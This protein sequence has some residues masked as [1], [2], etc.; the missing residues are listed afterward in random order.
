VI[1]RFNAKE[2]TPGGITLDYSKEVAKRLEAAG[3][4]LFN[5]TGGFYDILDY[6]QPHM[7][8]ED[9][10]EEEYYRFLNLAS[11]IKN[12]VDVP[13]V[14]GGLISDPF[15]AEK[16][17]EEGVVDMVFVA[18]QLFADPDWPKK[19]RSGRLE[20]IRPCI[21]CMDGC[22]GRNFFNKPGWCTVNALSGFEYRWRSE[23]ELPRPLKTKKV[24]I[25]GAGPAGLEAARVCAI[26]GHQVTVVDKADK[27]GGALTIASVPSFKKRLIRL[28]EWY[29]TQLDKLGV[30]I[31]LNAEATDSL[32]EEIAPDA[33]VVATGSEPLIP[34][35]PG[36]EKAF[37]ADDVLLDKKRVGQR[38]V[39]IG[40]GL[41]GLDTALWL[42]KQGKQVAVVEALP[43]AGVDMETSVRMTFF[44]EP[45]GL[46]DKYHITVM[47]KTPAIEVRD[48]GVVTVDELGCQKLIE[49]DSVICA[50]GRCS[51]LDLGI[52]Q[53]AEEFYIIGDARDSRKI[54]DAI[55]EGFTVA[56]DI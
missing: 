3:V 12:V 27:I 52:T 1:F 33:V 34:D 2:F 51:T 26:R 6:L 8:I 29:H 50:V 13:I 7:Y 24:L 44:R 48:N 9:E 55:H 38:I 11:E 36:I 14:S 45:G 41:V 39:V 35:I 28:V 31:R 20:D 22:I 18:R 40:G 46:L 43:K 15:K 54:I 25:I 53:D 16:L 37:T 5:V 56:L 47:T 10:M 23:A 17:L 21:L 30:E 32:I 42:A 49:G 19:V 4:N